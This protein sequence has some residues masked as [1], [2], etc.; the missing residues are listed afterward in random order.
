MK[1]CI[2]LVFSVFVYEILFPGL[3]HACVGCFISPS[4]G[5]FNHI[6]FWFWMSIVYWIIMA[7]NESVRRV[8]KV[9][10]FYE[11]ININSKLF[12]LCIILVPFTMGA[13]LIFLPIALC[14]LQA[15]KQILKTNEYIRGD[16]YSVTFIL[17]QWIFIIS[18]IA[19]FMLKPDIYANNWGLW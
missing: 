10:S 19:I 9:D 3:V 2:A 1:K 7:V 6:S 8:M 14:L 4:S 16:F 15:T 17:L 5:R 18:F 12:L 11:S 13:S